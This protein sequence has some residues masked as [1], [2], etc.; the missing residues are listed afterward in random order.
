[1]TIYDRSWYGRVLV[2]RVEKLASH[3]QWL[4]S[5]QEI[6]NFEEHLLDHNT[7]VIKFWIHI[8]KDEQERRFKA[9]E[10]DPLK[11][12]KITDEDWRNRDKW[13]QYKQAVN[14]MVAHTSTEQAPWVL[15]PG[16]NKKYAR[17]TVINTVCRRLEEILDPEPGGNLKAT[18]EKESR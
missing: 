8:S 1:M 4:R 15:V 5:Y 2:E 7:A 16:N 13:E 6:N 11:G 17:V 3:D 18:T 12:Y 9:R 10:T 14:D